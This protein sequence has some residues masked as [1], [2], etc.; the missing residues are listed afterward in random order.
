MGPGMMM[1]GMAGNTETFPIIEF[2][3]G[4]LETLGSA[5]DGTADPRAELD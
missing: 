5:T 3:A 4:K 2:R 1:G